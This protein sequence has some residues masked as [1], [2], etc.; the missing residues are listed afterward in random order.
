MIVDCQSS[1][2]NRQSTIPMNRL[3]FGL[4]GLML[5][6]VLIVG[7]IVFTTAWIYVPPDSW[8]EIF[9]H[10][11]TL[12]LISIVFIGC[13]FIA[14]A[15]SRNITRQITLITNAARTMNSGK[16][17][18]H[19]NIQHLYQEF[20][21]L[22]WYINSHMEFHDELTKNLEDLLRGTRS[23]TLE[24]RSDDDEFMKLMNTLI[25][26]LQNMYQMTRAV[27]EG[28]L[29]IL[30]LIEEPGIGPEKQTYTIIS[31]LGELIS[32][33]RNCTNQIIHAGSQIN[34]ITT[35]GLQDTKAATK[36]IN[37]ISQS[38]HQMAINIQQVAE[39]LQKQ[40]SLLDDTSTSIDQT[41]R[42]IEEIASSVTYL[43]SIIENN[44]SSSLASEKTASSLDLMY[45]ATK[46]IETDAN[47]CVI[48]SQE[49]AKD[50]EHGKMVVQQTIVGMNQI[51]ESMHEFFRI[52]RRLGDR[53]EEV[54]ETLEAIS[55]IADHTNLLAINAAIISAHA[56][57]HGRDFAV[58]ADEIGK[59]A[60]R[61]RESTK[62]IEELLKTIQ[63][64]FSDTTKAMEKSSKAVSNGV[65]LSHKAG[66]TLGKIASSTFNTK[67]IATRIATATADQSRENDHIR[68]IME[69]LVRSQTEKQ[70]QINNILWQLIDTIAQI[71]GITSEQA[72][73]S[74][75]IAAM[76]QNL[77]QITREIR[78][79]TSQ[80]VTT[81]DQ[82]IDAVN[83]IRKLVQ[84]TTHGTE[85]AAQ[86]TDELFTQGGN[87]A[88]TM[89]EFILSSRTPSQ[90]INVGT[91]SIGFIKRGSDAFFEYMAAGI[92]EE[93]EQQG[94]QILE[95]NSQYEATTQVENI[96]WLL[97]QPSLQGIILCPVDINVAQ[98]L[99]QK[100][101][102]QG[103][104]CISADESITNTISVRSGN[105]EGGR[106]AAEVF[107][108][109]L[110][111]NTVVG[112]IVDRTVESMV[113]RA[114][115]FRQRAEQYPFEI[116]EIYC[117]LSDREQ[118]RNYIVSG[119]EDNPELKGIFLTSE[120][121]TIAYLHA[122]H[123][124]LLPSKDLLAVGFDYTPTTEEAI[125]NGELL[126]AI[127]QHPEEIGKQAFQYL[128]K[129]IQKEIRVEDFD[130]RTIYIPTVAVTKDTLKT[131]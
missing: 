65:K 54:S 79:A 8:G 130:K 32:K 128:Y 46:A 125:R 81:A 42:S 127:F 26:H 10:W 104:P 21:P 129:L 52:V 35:Q 36:R 120:A 61:T 111:Q 106:R 51:Q 43:K 115:G 47:T 95:A 94:F 80:H 126:G 85:K 6:P 13:I 88:L 2:I 101:I 14:L 53:A 57:E 62:E 92:R 109:H 20:H 83:Y 48:R 103:I 84:R 40:S 59:F 11:I 56:G 45:K 102:G 25:M 66:K 131:M 44:P 37:D 18:H 49:A 87:L 105:R 96:N 16:N 55:D 71:R 1:I 118:V 41:M 15:L 97:K 70:E 38:I 73:G 9:S 100:G 91:S 68:D 113:R 19:I 22:Y 98:K 28:N 31:E 122:L 74:A 86:L 78:Q 3:T 34:S 77:D 76:A 75:R 63:A 107:I 82:I 39:H 29:A 117:D 69:E 93:A 112:V 24:L 114:E 17:V 4:I 64:E 108:E 7:F 50:A 67:E 123:E 116:L 121:V 110:Q 99:V 12:V 58:I 72:E 119:I 27:T 33:A 124:G 60:E 23:K 89:G 30:K 90:A 5:I